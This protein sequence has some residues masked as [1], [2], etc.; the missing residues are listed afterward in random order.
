MRR[1][2]A[3]AILFL[4]ITSAL[5]LPIVCSSAFA[6]TKSLPRSGFQTYTRPASGEDSELPVLNGM[7]LSPGLNRR[8]GQ[9]GQAYD[10]GDEELKGAIVRWD[11]KRLPVMVYISPGLKL[12][13]AP[14]E[15]LKQTATRNVFQLL[16]KPEGL[17][18]LQKCPGWTPE[19]NYA[20]ANGFE[21][22]RDLENEGVISFGFVNDPRQANVI[23]MFV[24]RFVD[25]T[26]AGGTS[27]HGYTIGTKYPAD[28]LWEL[29][30]KGEPRP[31]YTLT[32]VVMLLTA[33]ENYGKLSASACHE[34]GHVLGI[35]GHSPY[36]EDIMYKDRIVE[37][38][39]PADKA[40]LRKLYKTRPA[41]LY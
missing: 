18:V 23:V 41:Y 38:L 11:A 24:D 39:S 25:G 14:L 22:W 1:Q 17:S 2:A 7:H 13:D 31:N 37:T 29:E 12:P 40:T 21:Q 10:P 8:P 9:A 5:A 34:F 28:Q 35:V 36:R 3:A 27:V 33:D 4:F 15:V 6:Q 30:A 20:A 16:S 19:M 32:P 26:E